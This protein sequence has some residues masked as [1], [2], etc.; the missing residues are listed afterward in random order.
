MQSDNSFLFV[1]LSETLEEDLNQLIQ[2][3]APTILGFFDEETETYENT[4]DSILE[5]FCL[6]FLCPLQLQF[7]CYVK[8]RVGKNSPWDSSNHSPPQ[9]H[10]SRLINVDAPPVNIPFT[11]IFKLQLIGGQPLGEKCFLTKNDNKSVRE[12]KVKIRCN[13]KKK[14]TLS[15]VLSTAINREEISGKPKYQVSVFCSINN[16]L[17]KIHSFITIPLRNHKFETTLRGVQ[18]NIANTTEVNTLVEIPY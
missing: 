11:I 2:L 5:S 12:N 16:N 7:S 1:H 17:T 6:S 15:C 10:K 18:Q 14:E 13:G 3:T 9:I 4:F 8:C